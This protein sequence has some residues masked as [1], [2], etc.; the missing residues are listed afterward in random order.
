MARSS[1]FEGIYQTLV[2][3][4]AL[5][6]LIGARTTTNLR[7]YR[8]YPQ[9]ENF[10]TSVP[11]EPMA[12][13]GWIVLEEPELEPS[14]SHLM[15]DSMWEGMEPTF[16]VYT[17]RNSIADDVIDVLDSYWHWQVEQQRPVTYGDRILLRTRRFR[18]EERYDKDLKLYVRQA[19][20]RM[21]FVKEVQDA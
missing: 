12:Q 16:H 15:D 7:Y 11:Y 19:H 5:P 3:D 13:D 14:T 17:T 2:A 21:V 4:T 1:I 10:L 8:A 20:Y 18:T 9:F 6:A